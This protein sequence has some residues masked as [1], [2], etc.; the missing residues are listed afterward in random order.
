MI[1]IGEFLIFPM[2]GALN[3]CGTKFNVEAYSA[4]RTFEASLMQGKVRVKSP[5]NGKLAVV[6]LPQYKTTLKDGKLVVSKIDDYNVYR[7]KE[8]LICFQDEPI[9][10]I[11]NKLSL[12]FD[13]FCHCQNQCH[14]PCRTAEYQILTDSREKDYSVLVALSWI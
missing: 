5:A 13:N 4:G 12:Y 3:H 2:T 1:V 8:G 9:S 10:D 6:L 11:M 14:K 7:W